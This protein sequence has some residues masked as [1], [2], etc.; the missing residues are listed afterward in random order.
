MANSIVQVQSIEVSDIGG[1]LVV[2]SRLIAN[3][4]GIEHDTLF[5]TIEKYSDR[6][7]IKSELR[8]KIEFRERPQGGKSKVRYALLDERQATL[9][10]ISSYM[11]RGIIDKAPID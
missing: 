7:S 10:R 11:L 6:L 2:D 8:F 9:L 3:R 5:K 4:L 1:E